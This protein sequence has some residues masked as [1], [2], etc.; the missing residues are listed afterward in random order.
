[1]KNL[2]VTIFVTGRCCKNVA[3]CVPEEVHYALKVSGDEHNEGDDGGEDESWRRSEASHV[4]HGQDVR[5]K[6]QQNIFIFRS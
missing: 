5:L 3:F 2:I 1:M 4:N 6:V